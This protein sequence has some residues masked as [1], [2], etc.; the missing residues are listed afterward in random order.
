M[1]K[2]IIFTFLMIFVSAC[3]GSN[4]KSTQSLRLIDTTKEN[5]HSLAHKSADKVLERN[6]KLELSKIEANA[7]VEIEK[8]KSQ[9]Q[10]E[11]A[12]INAE[13]K[14][15]IAK[16]DY[17]AKIK[18]SELDVKSRKEN[19][20]YTVYIVLAVVFIIVLAIIVLYLNGKKNRELQK[21]LH[22]EKL[23]HEKFLKEKELEEQRVH[24]L[25]DLIAS[26]KMAKNVEK[27]VILS[28]TNTKTINQTN[29]IEQGQ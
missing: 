8:I 12:K 5:P 16:K 2:G 10:L 6:N 21:K 20:Q 19:M 15:T 17:E 3:G 27:E 29:Y 14:K 7:K 26:G 9:N 18:S 25:L 1:I 24:K 11:I 23:S 28:I 4:S 13:T 22:D